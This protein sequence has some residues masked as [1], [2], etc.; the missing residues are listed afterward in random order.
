M[1]DQSRVAGESVDHSKALNDSIY[2]V[3]WLLDSL[4]NN[5]LTY[6]EKFG[7]RKVKDVNKFSYI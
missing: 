4:R 7:S 1:L 5:D 6:R 2:T 3:G